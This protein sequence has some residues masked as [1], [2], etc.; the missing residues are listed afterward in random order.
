VSDLLLVDTSAWIEFLRRTGSQAHLELR[1]VL[2]EDPARIVTTEPVIMELLAGAT[3]ERS[4]VQLENLTNG[5]PLLPVES[6]IDYREAASIHR[7][8][9]R[10]GKTIRSM[11]DCLIAAVAL[12]NDATLV[13]KDIDYEVLCSAV[14]AKDISWR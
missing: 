1:R 4:L 9:R 6:R 3:S 7:A 11:V 2:A 14:G 10:A 5:L 12:R 8:T 13:H